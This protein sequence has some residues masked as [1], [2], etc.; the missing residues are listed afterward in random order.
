VCVYGIIVVCS[1]PPPDYLGDGPVCTHLAAVLVK[2]QCGGAR[3]QSMPKKERRMQRK[4]KNEN[5][6]EDTSL[7]SPYLSQNSK[8]VVTSF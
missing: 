7:G 4:Q 5:K 3:N 2:V 1:V 6:K 8:T